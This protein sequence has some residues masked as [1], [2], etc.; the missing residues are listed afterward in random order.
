MIPHDETQYG[1]EELY[2]VVRGRARFVCDGTE[3]DVGE[4]EVLYAAP[5]VHREAT[6]LE[7]TLLVLLGGLPGEA[8]H[9]PAWAVDA[10]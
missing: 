9:P 1:Q 3:V 4:G 2:L 5:A 6:A 8:Y 10:S 7:P